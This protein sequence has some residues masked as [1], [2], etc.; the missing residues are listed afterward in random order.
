MEKLTI[1]EVNKRI[2]WIKNNL[3][4]DSAC[5]VKEDQLRELFITNVVNKRYTVDEAS[6]IGLLIMSTDDLDFSRWYE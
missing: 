2:D 4:D 5:H 1:E 3:H 6:E